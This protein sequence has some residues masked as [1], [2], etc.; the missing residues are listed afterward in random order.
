MYV[1]T[2]VGGHHLIYVNHLL[3]IAPEESFAVLPEGDE[4]AEGRVVKLPIKGIRRPMDY[5]KWMKALHRIAKKERPD[6][7]HFLDGDT[8]MRYFGLGLHGFESARLVITFHHLFPGRLREISMR[9]MLSRAAAGV[10]H[11]EEIERT[12]TGYGCTNTRLIPYPCF[13][14]TSMQEGG[15]YHH[16]PPILLALGGTRYDK[17][18]DILLEALKK[19]QSPFHLIVAGKE[20]DFDRAYIE[21]QTADYLER[22]ELVLRFLEEEEVLHFLQKADIIVLPYRK[23]FDGASGPMNEGIYLG[24]TIVG[25]DHGS[26]GSLIERQHVGYTFAGEDREALASCLE[27]AL[28]N[29]RQYDETAKKAQRELLPE[30]FRERYRRLYEE[31]L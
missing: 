30:L 10:F 20:E 19:V 1:D 24:K 7:V 5:Q 21:E 6:I 16:T 2:S 3:Q 28:Q 11:T 18:L 17:G 15:S 13:L 4:T 14:K 9:R 12:V 23:V 27:K 8:M 29:P 22:P 31:I 25:P 26:L